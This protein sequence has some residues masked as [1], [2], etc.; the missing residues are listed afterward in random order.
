MATR[1]TPSDT[2]AT[3]TK[4]AARSRKAAPAKVAKAAAAKPAAKAA[5]KPGAPRAKAKAAP[6]PTA[7]RAPRSRKPAI[8]DN[9][10]HLAEPAIA[11]M[12]KAL[13]VL[14][15]PV[16]TAGRVVKAINKTRDANRL[17]RRVRNKIIVVTGAA[18]G[19]GEDCAIK[20][21]KAGATV[22]LAARTPEKLDATM[23]KIKAQGGKAFAY[24]CDIAEMADCDR[25]VN[26]VLE[27]HG[28]VDILINNA[29]RSIRRS[30][31]YSFDRFHDFERTMQLNY[32]GA[33]RLIMGFSPAMLERR[34]GHI[35]N[36]SSIG[37]LTHPPRFSAYVASKAA[38]DAFS[39]CAAS[40]YSDRN[41]HFT[42][43]YMPLVK[44]AMTAPTKIY[45]AFP[46]LTPDE[47]AAMVMEA[48]IERPTRIATGL[49]LAGAVSHALT[50]KVSEYILN[51][52]YHL[53]PD[54]ARARGLTDEE[55]ARE[56]E[57][58]PKGKLELARKLFVQVFQGV[59]W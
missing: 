25:F 21:A 52:A 6:A 17:S 29:G 22:I 30:L 13:D 38:L 40:E 44:T 26:L 9:L 12:S 57:A 39:A 19:I 54:S 31:Q 42:T 41:V 15:V 33:L 2:P 35:V 37:V 16:A 8:V 53:F 47:A 50:P 56:A 20:L 36:I 4:P 7:T 23:A 34:S 49:G 32:F 55:A 1:K 11:A 3:E 10:E 51:Q 24:S 18:A 28:H 27:K 45:N 5:A 43:I 48:I 58:L 14:P 46:M 59:H